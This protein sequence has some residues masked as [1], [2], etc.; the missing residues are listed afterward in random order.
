MLLQAQ[1]RASTNEITELEEPNYVQFN[2]INQPLTGI[3]EGK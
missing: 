1:P 3:A 2:I